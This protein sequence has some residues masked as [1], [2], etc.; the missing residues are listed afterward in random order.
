ML[1]CGVY[2]LAQLFARQAA[3]I[4]RRANRRDDGR[5]PR[6]VQTALREPVYLACSRMR[7]ERRRPERRLAGGKEMDCPA[8][9]VGLHQSAMLPEFRAHVL[10]RHASHA[11]ADGEFSGGHHLRVGAAYRTDNLDEI[12]L[13]SRSQ[14]GVPGESPRPYLRPGERSHP[15][16]SSWRS[17]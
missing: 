15:T 1:Q 7:A 13:G 17:S 2:L 10:T 14:Q 12:H 16:F 8:Q 4:Q 5:E 9:A 11:D 3:A 6:G